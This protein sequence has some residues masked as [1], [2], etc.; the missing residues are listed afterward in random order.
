[1]AQNLAGKGI[2]NKDAIHVACA[3][4]SSCDYFLSTDDVLLNKLRRYE[5]ITAVN[6]VE[7]ILLLEDAE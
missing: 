2:N 1:M 3:V 4:A 7:F 6:T 5:S